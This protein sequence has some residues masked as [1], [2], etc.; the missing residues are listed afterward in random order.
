MKLRTE[1][2]AQ[3]KEAGY[4]LGKLLKKGD[5]VCFYG[6][7]GAGKT[8][9]IKGIASAIGIEERDIT[10]ASF[11]IIA[12]YKKGTV[13]FYHIDLY[14]IEHGSADEIGLYDYIRG[15]GI[16]VIEWAER[17]GEETSERC[18][19]VRIAC[20]NGEERDIEIEGVEI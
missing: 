11:T 10:S 16:S 4:R 5:V 18:I 6:E 17:L 8:T 19:K 9:M 15:D 12:E 3:T 1:N 2:E 14:R 13:P 20:S 7:L